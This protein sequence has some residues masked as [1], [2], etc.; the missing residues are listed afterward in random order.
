MD[1]NLAVKIIS[2]IKDSIEY[3]I[4]IMEVCGTHTNSIA[5][6]GIREIFSSKITF[7]SGPGCPVCVTS[8]SYIDNAIKILNNKDIILTTFGDM[9]K[10]NGT[11][12]NLLSKKAQGNNVV[13]VYSPIDVLKI[14]Q[15]NPYKEIVFLA[16]GFETTAPIIAMTLKMAKEMEITNLSFYTA[17][18]VM[19]PVLNKILKQPYKQ[20]DGIICPG[21]VASIKG[22]EYFRFIFEEYKIPAV[23]AGFE[24]LDILGAI[25]FLAQNINKV[26]NAGFKNLYKRCVSDKGNKIANLI[27]DEVFHISDAIWRGIGIVENSALELNNR[28]SDYDASK[29]FG[30]FEQHVNIIN[31]CRCGDIILGNK[32]PFDCELFGKQCNPITPHGPCMVSSEGSCAINYRYSEGKL[33]GDK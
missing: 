21:H 24:A 20:I 5:K 2:R 17:L 11:H 12:E 13:I 33:I 19:N 30:L 7:L 9:L 6:Y 16:V 25:Y 29:I 10:V 26:N 8:E 4:R 28:Y 14:A 3:P 15:K 22:S 1:K 18:K 27:M 23:V 32:A 31:G